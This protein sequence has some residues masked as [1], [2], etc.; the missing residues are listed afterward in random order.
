VEVLTQTPVRRWRRRRA[1]LYLGGLATLEVVFLGLVVVP[2]KL[3][4]D[5]THPPKVPLTDSPALHGLAFS[6]ISFDSPLD[7]TTL[8]GWYIPALHPTGRTVVIAPGISDNR[9]AG[10][11]TL[12]L[13]P[14]L[15]DAGWDVLAF[16]FRAE[17]ES[18]GDTLSLGVREQDD[19]LGAIAFARGRGARH[20]AV[21]GYSMGAASAILAAA[22]SPDIEAIVADSAFA[23]LRDVIEQRMKAAFGVPD[24][25]APYGL[26][27]FGALSGTDPAS[28]VPSDIVGAVAPRPMLFIAGTADSLVPAMDAQT[29]A[30]RAGPTAQLWLVPGA[31]HVSSFAADPATYVARVV[32]FLEASIPRADSPSGGRSDSP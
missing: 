21:V 31:E 20:V 17:G 24:F 9:Q 7:G 3:M 28:A 23:D 2:V 10:G 27:L 18:D 16:D 12:S 29:L 25:L 6:S 15:L 1:F 13:A 30:E 26:F 32:A 5:Q 14:V 19:L 8:R 4:Y 22:R 11:I